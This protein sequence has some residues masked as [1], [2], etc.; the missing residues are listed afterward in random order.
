ML[1]NL[2]GLRDRYK[3]QLMYLTFS[4][5]ALA[6]LRSPDEWDEVEPFVELLSLRQIGLGPLTPDDAVREA[7]RFAGRHCAALSAHSREQIGALS[8]GH[9]ALVRALTHV[10]LDM[11]AV[12]GF[13]ANALLQ[14]A[15]ALREECAK[16][17]NGLSDDEQEALLMCVANPGN[18]APIPH[19]ILLKRLVQI[20][21]DGAPTIFSPLFGAAIAQFWGG[22]TF[23]PPPEP[24]PAARADQRPIVVDRERRLVY[25]YGHDI[26]AQFTDLKFRLIAHLVEHYGAIC[27]PQDLA[28]AVY[29]EPGQSEVNDYGRILTLVKRVR[30]TLVRSAPHKPGL[31]RVIRGRGVQLGASPDDAVDR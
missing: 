2:R 23:T 16:I 11:P 30:Q 9:P 3:Y 29:D 17:W 25:Y 1:H 13:K 14:A 18:T 19:H 28:Q 15:P 24:A 8:G 27:R 21:A 31:L 26:S 10:Y 7:D 5:E 4:R 20:N 6:D 12:V 22:T